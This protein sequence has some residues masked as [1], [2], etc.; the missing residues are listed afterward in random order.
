MS[1][2]KKFIAPLVILALVVVAAL[3]LFG[4]EEKKTLTAH[5]PRTISIYEGSDVRILGVPVGNVETVTPSGTDVVVTMSYDADVKVPAD[6]QALIIAPSIV[7]DRYVQ[8]TP[9]YTE[10]DVLAEG[11][12][13]ADYLPAPLTDAEIAELVTAAIAQTGAAD[14]GMR[15]MGKVMGVV[16]PQVKGRADGGAVAAEVRR[17]LG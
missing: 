8:L 16:T 12:V 9:A 3:T 13:I 4:G 10:G 5:F 1:T 7:G 11:E 15:A 6:A 17:Q 2:V 14:E